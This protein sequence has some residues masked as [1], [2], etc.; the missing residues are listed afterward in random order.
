MQRL[1][2][3]LVSKKRRGIARAD[4]VRHGEEDDENGS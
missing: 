3:Q 1:F 2:L 4:Y